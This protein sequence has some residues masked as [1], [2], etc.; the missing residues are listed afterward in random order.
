MKVFLLEDGLH[1]FQGKR[2]RELVVPNKIQMGGLLK[3]RLPLTADEGEI[4][5]YLQ[6]LRRGR[7]I[8]S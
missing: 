6:S 7:K 1:G 8:L 5:A 3:K 2:R 4:W